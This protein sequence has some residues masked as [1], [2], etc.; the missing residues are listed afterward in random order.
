MNAHIIMI[1]LLCFMGISAPEIG[2][3]STVEEQVPLKKKSQFG[4]GN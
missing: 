2:Y 1:M 4:N 3:T